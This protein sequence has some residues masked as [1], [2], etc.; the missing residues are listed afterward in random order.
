MAVDKLAADKLA[1]GELDIEAKHWAVRDIEVQHLGQKF[2]ENSLLAEIAV[3]F[4][5]E[6]EAE[7]EFPICLRQRDG[8]LASEESLKSFQR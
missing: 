4:A 8:E 2:Q 7:T 1:V 5:V 6:F 3:G